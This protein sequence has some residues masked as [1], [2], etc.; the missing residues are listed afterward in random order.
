MIFFA[1]IKNSFYNF[2]GKLVG[3]AFS[4]SR[5][6]REAGFTPGTTWMFT[7]QDEPVEIIH[8]DG[9]EPAGN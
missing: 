4:N 3:M 2:L 7:T 1:Q 6:V 8:S 5:L 9:F